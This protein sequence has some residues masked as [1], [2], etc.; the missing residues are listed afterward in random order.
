MSFHRHL[1]PD[2]LSYFQSLGLK[3][4]GG[5]TAKWFTTECRF[6]G[7]SDSMRINQA[8][9]G[10]VCMACGVKGGDLVAYEMQLTGDDFP[11]VC[12]RLGAWIDDGKAF[13]TRKP[14]SLAPRDALAALEVDSNFVYVAAANLANGCTLAPSDLALLGDAA[15][16]IRFIREAFQ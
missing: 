9:G 3:I 6:H 13:E 7:G 16:R 1:L 14:W 15:A 4:T 2:S 11:D 10:W 5:T 8:T 12:K